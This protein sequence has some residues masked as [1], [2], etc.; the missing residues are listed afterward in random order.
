MLVIIKSISNSPI[1]FS[2]LLFY[3]LGGEDCI[4]LSFSI[5]HIE[6]NDYITGEIIVGEMKSV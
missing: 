6:Q 2:S 5:F 1:L 3:F 4:P